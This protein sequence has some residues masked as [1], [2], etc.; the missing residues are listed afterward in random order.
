MGGVRRAEGIDARSHA[1]RTDHSQHQRQVGHGANLMHRDR[2]EG[3]RLQ[4]V[5]E[6]AS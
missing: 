4:G 1:E 2:H 5:P 3:L 6:V